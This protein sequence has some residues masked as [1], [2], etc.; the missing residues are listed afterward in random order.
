[1]GDEAYFDKDKGDTHNTKA[2]SHVEIPRGRSKRNH[3]VRRHDILTQMSYL[4]L[5]C[6]K[7]LS[8]NTS[9]ADGYPPIRRLITI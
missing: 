9:R 4:L 2:V 8:N 7:L 5:Q 1:M 6:L 3:Y